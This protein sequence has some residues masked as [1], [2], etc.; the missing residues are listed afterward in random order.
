MA[1]NTTLTGGDVIR[2]IQKPSG[3]GPK[4]Q[5]FVLD[6]GG[7]G[8]EALATGGQKAMA[9]SLPVVLPS[10]QAAIPVTLPSGL[11][12]SALQT[13]AN[14]LLT[15]LD[16]HVVTCNT[17]AVVVSTL[18]ALPA[19]TN[20][21]G[22]VAAGRQT[23]RYNGTTLITKGFAK[24]DF[25]SGGDVQLAAGVAGKQIMAVS[26]GG[27]V[28]GSVSIKFRSYNGSSYVDLTGAMPLLPNQPL[29]GGAECE[30]GL[31]ITGVGEALTLNASAAVQV[32][33]RLTY[34][35]V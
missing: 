32:S 16:T 3:S 20:L 26:Y 25:A 7:A 15:S 18:P 27:N 9:N 10:D 19:G 21:I 33:G 29:P 30:D 14:A 6:L 2:D 17:G 13:S 8:T 31:F 23:Q 1:D 35:V 11:A 22:Q 28:A 12:T 24:I 5:V 34:F 4:T